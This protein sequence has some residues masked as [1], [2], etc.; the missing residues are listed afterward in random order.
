M[1][2]KPSYQI[3]FSMD[4]KG[5]LSMMEY[6]STPAGQTRTNLPA[7]TPTWRVGYFPEEWRNVAEFDAELRMTGTHRGRSAA[8]IELDN[9]HF[10]E[11]YS[12]GLAGFYDAVIAFGVTKGGI[13]R[14]RWTF[15]KQGA[16]YA[17]HPVIP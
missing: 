9:A 12:M 13:I 8:R 10:H 17:L 7:G 3:P 15:R 11:S 14:G 1:A 16:N 5:K 2:K 4:D 6:T